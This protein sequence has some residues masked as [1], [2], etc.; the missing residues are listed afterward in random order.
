M[1]P[2]TA[3]QTNSAAR[4]TFALD[5]GITDTTNADALQCTP[6]GL[7]NMKYPTSRAD[8]TQ[9]YQ[10]AG[11]NPAQWGSANHSCRAHPR[12]RAWPV[13][14]IRFTISRRT[15]ERLKNKSGDQI[16]LI[17]ANEIFDTGLRNQLGVKPRLLSPSSDK[18]ITAAATPARAAP[19]IKNGTMGAKLSFSG[20]ASAVGFMRTPAS[21]AAGMQGACSPIA[22]T[23]FG[24]ISTEH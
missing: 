3:Q 20:G 14:P 17:A 24:F 12:R 21:Q 5:D 19:P 16:T 7:T 2:P 1:T 11:I 18:I 23:E 15:R 13:F 22:R 10:P 4:R 6:T 8:R 9:T